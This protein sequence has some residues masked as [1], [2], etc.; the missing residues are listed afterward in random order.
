[1]DISEAGALGRDFLACERLVLKLNRLTKGPVERM[2]LCI[3]LVLV[4]V[5]EG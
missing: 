4:T 3:Q 2:I 5:D 1:M